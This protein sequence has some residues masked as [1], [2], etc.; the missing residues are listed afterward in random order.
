MN[1]FLL[2]KT[3]AL[4][5]LAVIALDDKAYGVSI[6]ELLEEKLN[7]K[8]FISKVHVVLMRMENR[9]F[10]TS[11]FEASSHRKNQRRTKFYFISPSGKEALREWNLGSESHYQEIYNVVFN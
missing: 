9:G 4:V 1:P 3:E 5:L 8:M 6:L 2:S 11:K 10:V 7:K